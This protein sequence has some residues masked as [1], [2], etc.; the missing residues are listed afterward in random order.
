MRNKPKKRAVRE[1]DICGNGYLTT[2]YDPRKTCSHEC[3][4]ELSRKVK[5]GKTISIETRKK[6]SEAAKKRWSKE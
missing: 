5:L 6:M 3:F 2:T 1:C 4:R